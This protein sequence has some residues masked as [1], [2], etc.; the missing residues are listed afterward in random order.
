MIN[1]KEITTIEEIDKAIAL[2]DDKLQIFFKHSTACPISRM[3]YEKLRTNYPLDLSQ[4][5]IYYIGVIEQRPLSNYL[6]DKLSVKHESP[7]MIVLKKGKAIFDESHLMIN[8]T[9]LPTLL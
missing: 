3:A 2:S 6:A 9:I 8:A 7:Q 5:D 4:A 1:L